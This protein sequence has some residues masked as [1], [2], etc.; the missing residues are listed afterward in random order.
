MRDYGKNGLVHKT[1][2]TVYMTLLQCVIMLL[3]LTMHWG[4]VACRCS[5]SVAGWRSHTLQ[6]A[7]MVELQQMVGQRV[8]RQLGEGGREGEIDGGREGGRE[9][10]KEGGREGGVK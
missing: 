4:R 7:R 6:T 2:C 5:C 1:M 8:D 9:R 10:G 3:Q